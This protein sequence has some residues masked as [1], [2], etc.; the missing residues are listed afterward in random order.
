MIGSCEDSNKPWSSL[1]AGIC[2][3]NI[4]EE[5]YNF[6]ININHKIYSFIIPLTGAR[7]G[8]VG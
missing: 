4:F 3:N 7:S 5:E 6:K 1:K 2:L 8:V